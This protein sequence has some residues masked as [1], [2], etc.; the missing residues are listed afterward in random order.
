M[1]AA[2]RSALWHC[3]HFLFFLSYEETKAIFWYCVVKRGENCGPGS[4]VD[5]D[6]IFESRF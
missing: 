2:W 4:G 6:L 5:L 1:K 3:T